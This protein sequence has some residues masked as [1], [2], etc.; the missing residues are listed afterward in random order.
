MTVNKITL[1][2]IL[3]P[4]APLLPELPL[5]CGVGSDC[6]VETDVAKGEG[7]G[8]AEGD[9]DTF[10]IFFTGAMVFTGVGFVEAETVGVAVGDALAVGDTIVLSVG[11]G[12]GVEA[13]VGTAL[14]EGEVV[15][16]ANAISRSIIMSL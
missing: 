13:A 7:E 10:T 5:I 14:G 8:E 1:N 16:S 9:V 12:V 2:K 6:T 4:L 15:T 3:G 11:E